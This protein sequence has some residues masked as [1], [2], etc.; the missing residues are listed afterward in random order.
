MNSYK[1]IVNPIAGGGRARS[2]M[3][4]IEEIFKKSGVD[5]EIYYTKGPR[6][7]IEAART[8]AE[9]GF[10]IVVAAGGDGTVNEV[11]NG[12]A[13]TDSILAAI[14]GG[15]GNDFAIAVN[16][17]KDIDQACEAL[18][19]ADI[20]S[21]DLGRV[22]DRYFINSVGV[23]FDAAVALRANQG[24]KPLTGV[25]A[26]IYTFFLMLFSYRTIRMEIDMGS[27]VLSMSPMLVAV[28]IGQNYGGGMRIVPDAIQDDGLFDVCILDDMNRF[29]LGYHF[30]KVFSGNHVKMK[31]VRMY[32][33]KEITLDINESLPLHMEG[34]ILFGKH[35]HFTLEQKKMKVLTGGNQ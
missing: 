26:Y 25:S 13:E 20:K 9:K 27:E 32:R 18:L 21:I 8:A 2:L 5:F 23:G 24:V 7:A 31:Q 34:E 11:L 30:P 33:V 28:G 14:R 29:T 1:F 12:I 19:K 16:M 6:D 3:P 17:P 15:K 22:L 4:K 10:N 35:M